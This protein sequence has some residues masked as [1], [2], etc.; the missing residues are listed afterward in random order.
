MQ[1]KNNENVMQVKNIQLM[2]YLDYEIFL[3]VRL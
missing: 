2:S 3:S 1:W